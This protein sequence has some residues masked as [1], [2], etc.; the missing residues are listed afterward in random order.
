MLT[1]RN[2]RPGG[3]G[4]DA[5]ARECLHLVREDAA[6]DL[7]EGVAADVAAELLGRSPHEVRRL[8]RAGH[9]CAHRRA[10]RWFV[11][12]SEV[13]RLQRLPQPV[14]RPFTPGSAWALLAMLSG[15]AAAEQSGARLMATHDDQVE[16]YIAESDVAG[17]HAAYGLW[18]WTC[19]SP[20]TQ[21]HPRRAGDCSSTRSS[22]S[23]NAEVLRAADPVVLPHLGRIGQLWSA[24]ADV[25]DQ[26][27]RGWTLIGALMVMLHEHEAGTPTR[28]ATADADAVVDARGATGATR[29]MARLL[30]AQSGPLAAGA[31][32]VVFVTT[33]TTRSEARCAA[34]SRFPARHTTGSS[35]AEACRPSGYPCPPSADENEIVVG[36]AQDAIGR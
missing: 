2:Q 25:A 36:A 14:G 19:G 33:A 35:H 29:T 4:E 18:A 21:V 20:A 32:D 3:G 6:D 5:A 8:L 12:V 30:Q 26:R 9:L 17:L 7:R 1:R 11:P 10:G 16:G 27:T 15:L 34:S 24:V 31:R 22:P 23:V 13:R 28:P